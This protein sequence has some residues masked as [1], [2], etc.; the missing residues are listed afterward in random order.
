MPAPGNEG[1]AGMATH[2]FR[3]ERISW[4]DRQ[5][6]YD[7]PGFKL[8]VYLE[9]SGVKEFNWVACDSDFEVWS[10]PAKTPIEEGK[11]REILD[12]LR[13]WAAQAKLRIGIG[14]GLTLDAYFEVW[15]SR[16][17]ALNGARTARSRLILLADCHGGHG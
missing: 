14:P 2:T 8:V 11:R 12:R 9:R 1:M 4:K 16:D 10:E 3:I 7:E 13:A 17:I 6:V 5:L 15:S